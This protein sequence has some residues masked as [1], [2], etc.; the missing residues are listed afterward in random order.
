MW[1]SPGERKYGIY[2]TI[3]KSL[4]ANVIIIVSSSLAHR[5]EPLH[6]EQLHIYLSISCSETSP[7]SPIRQYYFIEVTI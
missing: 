7:L 4:S 2:L 6:R 5:R 1:V 3:Y